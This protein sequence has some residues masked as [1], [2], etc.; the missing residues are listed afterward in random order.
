M[1]TVVHQPYDT[2]K[3]LGE[4][5]QIR[6]VLLNIFGPDA[7]QVEPSHGAGVLLMKTSPP[8]PPRR[9]RK[10]ASRVPQTVS[11]VGFGDTPRLAE[12]LTPPLTVIR[13]PVAQIAR[14]AIA[15]LYEM[16]EAET[17]EAMT[18]RDIS[19]PGQLMSPAPPVPPQP[20]TESQGNQRAVETAATK[21]EIHPNKAS[22]FVD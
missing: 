12:A 9:W 19:L 2:L 15:A 18:E 17:P 4:R 16:H 20:K 10:S 13:R 11:L 3:T 6:R 7:P 1:E 8:S 14:A 21:S 5:D 22:T